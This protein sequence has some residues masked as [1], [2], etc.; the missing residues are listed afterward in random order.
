MRPVIRRN[1]DGSETVSDNGNLIIDCNVDARL[2]AR[3]VN[4]ELLAMPESL[5]DCS[6][7]S[8]IWCWWRKRTARSG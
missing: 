4:Q 5:P 6:W 7:E 8:R 2:N 3:R 1:P